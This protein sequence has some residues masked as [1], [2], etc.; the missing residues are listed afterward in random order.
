MR[1]II[2]PSDSAKK[3]RFFFT[4]AMVVPMLL[5]FPYTS[6]FSFYFYGPLAVLNLFIVGIPIAF[7]ILQLSDARYKIARTILVI[8]LPT[9]IALWVI[10]GLMLS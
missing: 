10:W 3:S 9:E 6:L 7:A 5:F 4:L 2:F 8:C 1:Q